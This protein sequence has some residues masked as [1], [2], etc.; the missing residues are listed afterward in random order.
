MLSRSLCDA[1]VQPHLDY[2][3]S[4]WYL[5]FAQEMKNEIQISQ[6]K[7]FQYCLYLDKI[8]LF[9]NISLIRPHL[10]EWSFQISLSEQLKKFNSYL[11]LNFLFRKINR[12]QNALFFIASSNPRGFEKKQK[13]QQ[14][15]PKKTATLI[16][17]NMAS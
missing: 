4:A 2:A 7:C 6:N 3:S 13:K 15:N 12:G 9:S 11:K 5:N 16:L 14:K 8:Q 10:S 1:L 17:S